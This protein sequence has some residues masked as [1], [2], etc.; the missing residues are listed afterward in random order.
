MG[1]EREERQSGPVSLS[2]EPAVLAR[3]LALR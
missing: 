2:L 1:Q 3:A